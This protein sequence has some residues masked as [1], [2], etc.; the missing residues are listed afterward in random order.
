MSNKCPYEAVLFDL[1]GT[2][3]DTALDLGKTTNYVL[4]K[5]Q[6]G[7]SISD[8]VARDYASD[9]MRA[10]MKAAIPENLHQNYDFE[11]MR[12]D[13]LPYY[14]EHIADRTIFF[15]H[16]AQILQKL[17]ANKIPFAV[18]TNKPD[19]LAQQLLKKFPEFDDMG[20]LVGCDLLPVSKPDPAPLN[21]ACEKLNV[22]PSK[23]VYIGDHKRDIE[24]GHNAHMDTIL[25]AW[26]YIKKGTN[27]QGFN[28]EFIANT[29]EDLI[30]LLNLL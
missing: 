2:L 22:Q 14:Y 8:D 4:N 30:K 19:H 16:I 9:G 23:C 21:Y 17:T 7:Y 25:A 28:A 6:T 27:L 1:D 5:Y 24:A 12:L 3:L 15:P 20:C 11:K 26:G 29:P 10:L 13:F 18:V